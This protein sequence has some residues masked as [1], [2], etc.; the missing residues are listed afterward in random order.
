MSRGTWSVKPAVIA[1]I[2]NSVKSTG[3]TVR[4]VEVSPDSGLVRVNVVHGD[5]D[6]SP[7]SSSDENLREL[8]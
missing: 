2:I 6:R 8:L 3:F 5:D 7:V 4:S 1:R